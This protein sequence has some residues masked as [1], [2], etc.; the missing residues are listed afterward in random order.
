M[1]YS[2]LKNGLLASFL[3]ITFMLGGCSSKIE[4]VDRW[5]ECDVNIYNPPLPSSPTPP[6][7]SVVTLKKGS[8][9][10]DGEVIVGYP[11]NDFINMLEFHNE[12]AT[13]QHQ[14]LNVINSYKK[15][16]DKLSDKEDNKK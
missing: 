13:Y 6:S 4:Y 14:L 8:Q 2:N 11:Y 3:V 7:V 12:N 5:H 16:I 9:I 10:K 15:Q 1:N